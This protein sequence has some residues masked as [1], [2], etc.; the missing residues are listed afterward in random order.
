MYQ[1][2]DISSLDVWI[3]WLLECNIIWILTAREG[4][5][6]NCHPEKS[7]AKS[8]F[9]LVFEGWEF[10]MLPSRAV[11]IYYIILNANEIDI[12]IVYLTFGFKSIQVKWIFVF[13]FRTPYIQTLIRR[14]LEST[15]NRTRIKSAQSIIFWNITR[16]QIIS[17]FANCQLHVIIKA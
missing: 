3:F 5:M 16:R 11:K 13:V 9:T 6:G 14:H 17:S 10:S 4:N 15:L 2:T 1:L 12:Y 7:E 8:R